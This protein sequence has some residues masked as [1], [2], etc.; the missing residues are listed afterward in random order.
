[1]KVRS[2]FVSNSSSSSF[3]IA[4]AKVT[5][6]MWVSGLASSLPNNGE[7]ILQS[8][9]AKQIKKLNEENRWCD[10][11]GD[12][13]Y[14]LMKS[15]TGDQVRIDNLLDDDYIVTL[16]YTAGDDSDFWNEKYGEM[17]YD[18]DVDFFPKEIVS[19]AEAMSNGVRGFAPGGQMAYGAGRNG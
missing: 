15:F 1:M 18:I 5:D 4:I 11:E 9:T 12:G 7:G 8:Y 19:V 6:P 2:G 16:E 3:I 10:V 14:A 17:D 13:T